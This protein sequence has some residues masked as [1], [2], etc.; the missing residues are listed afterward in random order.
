MVVFL[1]LLIIA[2]IMYIFALFLRYFAFFDINLKS[3]LPLFLNKKTKF[4]YKQIKPTKIG[5]IF[6]YCFSNQNSIYSNKH[7]NLNKNFISKLSSFVDNK[8]KE[9]RQKFRAVGS[10]I[11]IDAVALHIVSK[12]TLSQKPILFSELKRQISVFKLNKKETGFIKILLTKYL[13]LTLAKNYHYT[14]RLDREIQQFISSKNYSSKHLSF[15]KSYAIQKFNPNAT[16][17][18]TGLIYPTPL[19]NRICRVYDLNKL[20]ILYL[21]ILYK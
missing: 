15:A 7:I 2:V 4:D 12:L 6:K 13:L 19:I 9:N 16:K 11:L 14:I 20:I 1:I 5:P 17:F 21:K 8:T 18:K 10:T 3:S